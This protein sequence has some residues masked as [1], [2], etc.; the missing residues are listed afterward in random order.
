MC[1]C[2][3]VRVRACV[4][5]CVYVYLCSFDVTGKR[6]KVA[7]K[8][9]RSRDSQDAAKQRDSGSG[10]RKLHSQNVCSRKPGVHLQDPSEAGCCLPPLVLITHLSLGLDT[11]LCRPLLGSDTVPRSQAVLLSALLLERVFGS[12]SV[13]A[14]FCFLL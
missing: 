10:P 13:S 6:E 4:C 11:G 1:T 9:E 12:F 14:F 5:T 7:F 3:C 2:T 8:I